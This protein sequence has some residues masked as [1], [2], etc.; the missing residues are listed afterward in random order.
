MLTHRPLGQQGAIH[1]HAERGLQ[2]HIHSLTHTHS[3]TH[4]RPSP[5]THSNQLRFSQDT[6]SLLMKSA[7]NR[8]PCAAQ[9][10]SPHCTAARQHTTAQ[11]HTSHETES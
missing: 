10:A 5:L 2:A 9:L 8:N 6:L 3:L 11:N 7:Q 1:Q 4:Q